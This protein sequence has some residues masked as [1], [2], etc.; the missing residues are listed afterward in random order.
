MRFRTWMTMVFVVGASRAAGQT[1]PSIPYT[2]ITISGSKSG[3]G[4]AV[5][6]RAYQAP[7]ERFRIVCQEPCAISEPLIFAAYAGF[8]AVRPELVALAGVDII[9]PE[10]PLYD[11]HLNGDSYCG[12][13]TTGLTGDAS[14]YPPWAGPVGVVSC[15]WDVEKPNRA[16]AFT[17]E[18]AVKREDQLL[19]VHEYG[20][21]IFFGRHFYSYE[22]VVKDFSFNVAGINGARILDLCDPYQIE[23]SQ[24]RL[25]YALCRAHGFQW[26]NLAPAMQALESLFRSGQ[27]R[28]NVQVTNA[29]RATS[30]AQLRKIVS[31]QLGKDAS[32]GFA[33]GLF[34]IDAGGEIVFP[35][36]GGVIRTAGGRAAL[37]VPPGAVPFATEAN[38]DKVFTLP[39]ANNGLPYTDFSVA[40]KIDGNFGLQ[41]PVRLALRYEPVAFAA[42]NVRPGLLRL[43][44]VSGNAWQPLTGTV[45]DTVNR[46]ASTP[47]FGPGT[48]MLVADAGPAPGSAGV[49]ATVASLPGANNSYFRTQLQLHNPGTA[50][51][52]G[53]IVYRPRESAPSPSDPSYSYTLR[54]RETVSLADLFATLGQTGNGSLEVVPTTGS[55]PVLVTRVFNDLGSAGTFG[56]G[57]DALP[58]DAALRVGERGVLLAPRS[59][60]QRL[61][62]GVR[63][64][65]NGATLQVTVRNAGGAT[66]KSATK[67][68][69]AN[70]FEQR[71]L[72]EFLGGFDF[73]GD[74]SI[75]VAVTAGSALVYGAAADNRTNDP[76][77][78]LLRPLTRPGRGE[79]ETLVLPTV[80]SLPGQFGAFFRTTLQIHNA[81]DATATGALV[82][83][84][85]GSSTPAG[86]NV[87]YSLPPRATLSFADYLPAAGLSGS[88]T[89]DVVPA[90][91]PPPVTIARVYNDGETGT[92][93]LAYEARSSWDAL[94]PGDRGILVVPP[95][96]VNQRL[97][98]GVRTL[99]GGAVATVRVYDA[100][101][102]R[103]LVLQKTWPANTFEQKSLADFLGGFNATAGSAVEV[104][105][106]GGDLHLYGATGDNRTNDPTLQFAARA[107]L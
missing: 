14:T 54:F 49:V 103:R 9:T 72:S 105:L 102:I 24:G 68:Y 86:A 35:S 89:L 52:T 59:A 22:D 57:E 84:P 48:Y 11:L 83:R 69:V 78:Q 15:F 96:L 79:G 2:P 6:Y 34:G 28:A 39:A 33:A 66:V 45:V 25:L 90:S 29:P 3:P 61:N 82:Y 10:L 53:K 94:K 74:E 19:K 41:K 88:G 75:E 55:T 91:G 64:L 56:V 36:A 40:L 43:W 67:T 31:D 104:W 97:N 107:T 73:G 51:A 71:S 47:I 27:G 30:V 76:S 70:W 38:L 32:D 17:P 1:P 12:A 99:A 50:Q 18:N 13:Y 21:G 77:L 37:V 81:T 7:G 26:S 8:R 93:G 4:A 87:T 80:A 65:S 85:A 42:P 92:A 95:E 58:E 44:Q 101:G 62:V 63:A 5:T 16:L 23:A 98:I 46:V 100:G 60:T 106:E 20:H